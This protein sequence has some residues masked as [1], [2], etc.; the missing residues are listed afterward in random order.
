[1]DVASVRSVT[2]KSA[3]ARKAHWEVRSTLQHGLTLMY[4]GSSFNAACVSGRQFIQCYAVPVQDKG[5]VWCDV[6]RNTW[7]VL[8]AMPRRNS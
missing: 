5:L 6:V 4:M 3:S 2:S 8:Q 1:M 7:V